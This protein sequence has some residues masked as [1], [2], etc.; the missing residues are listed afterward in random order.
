MK[1][2]AW[3]VKRKNTRSIEIK[4]KESKIEEDEEDEESNRKKKTI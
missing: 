4:R 2:I 1:L 3:K